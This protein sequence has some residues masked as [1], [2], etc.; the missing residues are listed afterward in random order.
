MCGEE[1]ERYYIERNR[2]Y[3]PAEV[4]E[5]NAKKGKQNQKKGQGRKRKRGGKKNAQEEVGQ[6]QEKVPEESKKV[7]D[8]YYAFGEALHVAYR[9]ED[10]D[11]YQS[12][13]LVLNGNY[14][15][16]DKKSAEKFKQGSGPFKGLH[17]L[18]KRILLWC[19]PL[20]PDDPTAPEPEGGGFRRPELIPIAN[21]F[22][23]PPEDEE[24]HDG[25]KRR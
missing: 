1:I 6:T 23:A 20:E 5:K 3:Y 11:K 16:K 13:T 12:A 10:V 4:G 24:K 18:S 21:L 15:K 22:R 8:V 7:K 19:Y 14:N 25:K 9:T 2:H 17:K